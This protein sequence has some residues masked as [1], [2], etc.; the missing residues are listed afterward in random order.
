MH[1]PCTVSGFFVSLLPACFKR[2]TSHVLNLIQ[3]SLNKGFFFRHTWKVWNGPCIVNNFYCKLPDSHD[4]IFTSYTLFCLATLASDIY[5][6]QDDFAGDNRL[7]IQFNLVWTARHEL[8]RMHGLI[9][10]SMSEWSRS[11]FLVWTCS[12]YISIC[13]YMGQK[14]IVLILHVISN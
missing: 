3:I 2:R 6:M 9:L 12:S 8:S 1:D 11:S 10:G 14:K 5:S 4:F 7:I 13:N